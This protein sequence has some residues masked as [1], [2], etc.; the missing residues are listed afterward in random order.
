MDE[1]RDGRNQVT[2]LQCVEENLSADEKAQLAAQQATSS[3]AATFASMT[4]ESGKPADLLKLLGS[5]K[6]STDVLLKMVGHVLGIIFRN[7]E[8]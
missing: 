5:P 2:I 1:C 4:Q 8:I 6:S 7:I 3:L